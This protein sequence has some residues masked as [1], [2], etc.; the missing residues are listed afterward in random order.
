MLKKINYIETIQSFVLGEMFF[1]LMHTN[2]IHLKLI[3]NI[4]VYLLNPINRDELIE[5]IARVL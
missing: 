1:H 2:S 3:V 5:N 4:L